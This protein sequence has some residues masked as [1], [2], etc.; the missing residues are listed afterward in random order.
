MQGAHC[1]LFVLLD[2]TGLD[3]PYQSQ[4]V[5]LPVGYLSAAFEFQLS[6]I[7]FGTLNQKNGIEFQLSLEIPTCRI[8]TISNHEN[9]YI[10][11]GHEISTMIR[12]NH[13]ACSN[14]KSLSKRRTLVAAWQ[15]SKLPQLWL[16]KT[17]TLR[18]LRSW[19]SK[20]IMYW[21]IIQL[22]ARSWVP[23]RVIIWCKMYAN[24]CA[25]I[26]AF[27]PVIFIPHARI[28]TGI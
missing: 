1:T 15:V 11:I 10:V 13:L 2:G 21:L 12:F 19:E 24:T 14:L 18:T 17:A 3:R 26:W 7:K 28:W 25:A 27:F 6:L 16:E 4:Q 9:K 22:E 8:Q 23:T 5:K 20:W